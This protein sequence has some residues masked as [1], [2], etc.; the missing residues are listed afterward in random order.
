MAGTPPAHHANTL[1][2]T[3]DHAPCHHLARPYGRRLP[4]APGE[5]RPLRGES[6]AVI[7]EVGSAVNLS[8]CGSAVEGRVRLSRAG[9]ERESSRGGPPPEDT[10][11]ILNEERAERQSR[12]IAEAE[13]GD[14]GG[15][16]ASS[17]RGERYTAATAGDVYARQ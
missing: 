16:S 2:V 4:H 14:D 10:L 17:T 5:A 7:A 13:T 9:A 12:L 8:D 6:F 1:L 3:R 15:S 11:A